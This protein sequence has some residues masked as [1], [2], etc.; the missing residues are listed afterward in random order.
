MENKTNE[1]VRMDFPFFEYHP[2]LSYCDNAATT[3]KPTVVI[4]AVVNYYQKL[5][6]N[7]HRGDYATSYIT[8]DLY[9]SVRSQAADFIGASDGSQ[10][11]FTSGASEALNMVAS[12][13]VSPQLKEGDVVLL[14]ASEH[15]SN[16]LPWFQLMSKGIRIEFIA[17]DHQGR[18]TEAALRA[19][20]HQD[21]K[22][23]A[24]AHVSNVLGYVND[25][26]S[27]ASIIH[28]Y[29]AYFI[30]D[31]AQAI[32]HVP[33]DIVD[34][35]VDFYAFS[36][37]KMLGPTGV[38]V[39]Y[40]KRALLEKMTP[41]HHGGGTNISFNMCGE[42]TLKGI[43]HRF[44]S[45]TPNIEGVLGFGAAMGYLQ[46]YGMEHIHPAIMPLIEATLEGLK[47]MEHITVYNP[48]TETGI[49]T[50]S[51]KG[52]FAQ[53]VASY[54]NDH[55]IAV[56]AGDHCAKMLNG[57]L[58]AEQ[59]IRIS[60]YIYNTMHDVEALLHALEHISLEATL[61]FI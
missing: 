20:M 8:S 22:C 26:K 46:N 11:I 55:G 18:V 5:S 49:I 33:V 4:E 35:D 6:A 29:G 61:S 30:V 43:P 38:G 47:S 21:V 7:I 41:L 44:E 27:F 25:I 58:Q 2:T 34:L 19:A 57:V 28:E 3:L 1:M 42:V 56:R 53:D 50:L 36:A 31:G 51:V 14:N 37:H 39:L 24:M 16:T 15:A 9:E 23:V 32:G 17:L 48:K 12:G 54:L 40:G 10:I 13:F 52:I 45:G 60:Y 59:S